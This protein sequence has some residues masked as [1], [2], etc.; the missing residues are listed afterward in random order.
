MS[1]EFELHVGFPT[2]TELLLLISW[3][4]APEAEF[5]Q[6]MQNWIYVWEHNCFFPTII[7]LYTV[8]F[9]NIAHDGPEAQEIH[10]TEGITEVTS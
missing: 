5:Y 4:S 7:E 2:V 3:H 6:A 8:Y 1:S 9:G 10:K